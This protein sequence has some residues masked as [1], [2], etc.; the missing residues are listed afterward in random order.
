MQMNL[1]RR[2]WML[3]LA[4]AATALMQMTAIAAPNA[5]TTGLSKL[6]SE[7]YARYAWVVLFSTAPPANAVPLAQ[8]N[9][10]ELQ[11]IFVPDLAMAIWED[12][13][14]IEKRGEICNL[15]FDIL[16]DSQDPSASELTVQGSARTY[17]ALACF[18]VTGGARK[19]LLFVGADID[20]AARVADIVYPGQRSLRQLLGL[21]TRLSPKSHDATTGR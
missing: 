20:G 9:R 21:T 1:V 5:D 7:L 17:E 18:K 13:Q 3:A 6:V 15:D 16:F 8:T 11:A 19:C 2:L 10:A 14:C 12:S 4:W